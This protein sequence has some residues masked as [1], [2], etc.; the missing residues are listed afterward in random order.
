MYGQKQMNI[1][2]YHNSHYPPKLKPRP[3]KKKIQIKMVRMLRKEIGEGIKGHV[4]K[5]K[6]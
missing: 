5:E 3:N 2:L 4:R 1:D 6:R